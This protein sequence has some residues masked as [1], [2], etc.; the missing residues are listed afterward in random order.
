[1]ST[2]QHV[3]IYSL[4]CMSILYSRKFSSAKNFVKSDRQAVRQEFIFVERR[5]S[6]VCSLV[7]QSCE[8]N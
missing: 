3:V 8:K 4:L 1:M 5:S 2:V 6:L 7:I